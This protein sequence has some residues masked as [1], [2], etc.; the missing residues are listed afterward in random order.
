MIISVNMEKVCYIPT[1]DENFKQTRNR[2][3]IS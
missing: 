2:R 1:Y 3:Q